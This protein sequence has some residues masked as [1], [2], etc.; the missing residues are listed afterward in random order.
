[1]HH[2]EIS[3]YYPFL[4]YETMGCRTSMVSLKN[5]MVINIT[6]SHVQCRVSIG[7]SRTILEFQNTHHSQ[8]ISPWEVIGAQFHEKMRWS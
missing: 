5:V 1:M 2:L 8:C 6:Q 4:T 3:K 7:F